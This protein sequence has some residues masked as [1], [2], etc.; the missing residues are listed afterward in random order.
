MK[1][2]VI[3]KVRQETRKVKIVF[4]LKKDLQE[5]EVICEHCHGTGLEI[6]NNVY[7]IHGD[8][9]HV[10][11]RFPYKHQSIN[12]CRYCYNGI[13]EKCPSCGSLRGKK[14]RECSCGKDEKLR[15]EKWEKENK[16]KWE[17]TSKIPIDEAWITFK[18]LYIDDIDRYVFNESELEDLI[19]DYELK[20]P[21]IFGTT[22]IRINLDA[23]FIV[24]NACDDLH[25]EAAEFCDTEKLQKIL[26]DWCKEQDG[27]T[28]YSPNYKVG[29]IWRG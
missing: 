24:E 12:Y 20:N 28:S 7:G 17:K 16:E 19:E 6:A 29:V 25:E 11:V 10:G 26:D 1:E 2:T 27:T 18:C 14:D 23:S 3:P 15:Y 21:K 13:M 5:N 8:T 4:E 22:E 9:T